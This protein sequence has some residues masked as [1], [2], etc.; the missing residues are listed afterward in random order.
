V[1]A[2]L[3]VVGILVAAVAVWLPAAEQRSVSER[4]FLQMRAAQS[5][6]T[7]MLDQETGVRGYALTGRRLFLE[8]YQPGHDDFDAAF[9]DALIATSGD[10]GLRSHVQDAQAVARRWQAA[11]ERAI[12]TTEVEGPAPR[13]DAA[14]RRKAIM[15]DFRKRIATVMRMLDQRRQQAQ[16]R[17]EIL[18]VSVITVLSLLFILVGYALVVRPRRRADD[19]ARRARRYATEQQ[20]FSETMQM[21]GCEEEAHTMLKHHL[22]R[23]LHTAKAVILRRNNS[24][25]RLDSG[26]GIEA[27]EALTKILA[28]TDA[29]SCLSIRYGRPHYEGP[30]ARPLLSCKLC[31]AV[32]DANTTCMPSLVGGQVIGSVLVSHPE[33]LDDEATARVRESITQAG[34]VLANLRT[35]AQA[36]RRAATDSLTGLPNARAV[37]DTLKRMVAQAARSGAELTAIMID[38]DRFKSLNDDFGHE[39]GNEVL[40]SVGQALQGTIRS[41]DFAGRYG[42]EEF[43]VLLPDTDRAGGRAVAEK[44]LLA[45]AAVDV[46]TVPRGV[47][48]S[49]G[50]ATMPADAGDGASVVRQADRALYMAKEHGRGRVEVATQNTERAAPPSTAIS[51]PVT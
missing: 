35:I 46:P 7:A 37:Q 11:A 21:A 10:R 49:L 26:V 30:D 44:L 18:P 16:S 50:V 41:S 1:P 28:E 23:T 25:N 19:A 12:A 29:R 47:T 5:M 33:P 40:A 27:D 22:E 43:I 51:S 3:C 20:E 8:S 6:L 15:D 45:I 24:E 2:L 38:L 39:A 34:P 42:G 17:A 14:L 48:A 36:E 13:V 32:G 31:G 9:S 4:T